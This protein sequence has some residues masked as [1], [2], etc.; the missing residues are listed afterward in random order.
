M[1]TLGLT[2]LPATFGSSLMQ[3]LCG[4]SAFPYH[5]GDCQFGWSY[6]LT[7]IGTLLAMICPFVVRCVTFAYSELDAEQISLSS[8]NSYLLDGNANYL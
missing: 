7:V 2:L 4:S 6:A 3:S 1:M 8:E 5:F